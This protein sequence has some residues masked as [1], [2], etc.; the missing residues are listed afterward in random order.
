MQL[1]WLRIIYLFHGGWH[2]SS[3]RIFRSKILENIMLVL[4]KDESTDSEKERSK[5]P[6]LVERLHAGHL[7]QHTLD[8][9]PFQLC[10]L[11]R[12]CSLAILF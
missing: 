8:K 6:S 9:G 1:Q 3:Q 10:G 2:Y 12:F 7:A 4:P 5:E 11:L